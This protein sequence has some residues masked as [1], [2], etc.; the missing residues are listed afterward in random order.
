MTTIKQAEIK[1]LTG[2]RGIAALYVVLYHFKAGNFFD[3]FPNTFFHHGYLAVDLFFV[4]SGFVMALTYHS[5]FIN[6]VTL[7]SYKE[8]MGRRVA[9]I[10]P[11]FL[12]MTLLFITFYSFVPDKIPH[13]VEFSVTAIISNLLMV[14]A[15]GVSP[16]IVSASWSISTEF[17]AYILFPFLVLLIFGHQKIFGHLITLISMVIII[18]MSQSSLGLI[19]EVNNVSNLN[20][21]QGDTP[22][23]LIRC[24]CEFIIGIW[25]Y[26]VYRDSCQAQNK[27]NHI[28]QGHWLSAILAIII[29]CGL[30]IPKIDAFVV[31]LLPFLII[32][33]A[34]DSSP[35][36]K[37]I[38]WKPLY[39]LGLIS[40]SL[41]LCHLMIF[42]IRPELIELLTRYQ[43][44]HT[45]FVALA[46]QVIISLVTASFFYLCVERP[47]RVYFRKLL[48]FI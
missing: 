37:I 28:I 23:P 10:Y 2:L 41:Y 18:I 36:A 44:P 39:L 7:S 25:A 5:D 46:I 22:Y 3:G 34:N 14:Q 31:F 12:I 9:R 40:Y 38:G 4:L 8:F 32:S 45:Q 6:K 20:I 15:W 33:L 29:L 35:I 26:R 42:W 24:L 47:G 30:C 17:A 1:S 13:D 16:S 48:E 27:L 21:S 11:L 19:Y 43:I